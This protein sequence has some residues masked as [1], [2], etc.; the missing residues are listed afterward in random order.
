MCS[1]KAGSLSSGDGTAGLE[2]GTLDVVRFW[3]SNVLRSVLEHL[4]TLD[5]LVLKSASSDNLN[6]V[7]GGGMSSGHLHVHLGDGTAE[8][9][10]S[11]LLVHVNG[12]CT[13]EVTEND[14]V[15]V[16][17]TSLLLEDLTGGDDLALDL[18]DLVLSLHVIPELRPGKNGVSLE[19]SHSVE[20]GVRN[21]LSSEGSSDDKEL[22][23]LSKTKTNIRVSHVIRK[24][25]SSR[26]MH[27]DASN[28]IPGSLY[29]PF[30]S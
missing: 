9:D 29:L 8:R 14:S 25:N 17:G 23:Q 2:W 21:L 22:S 3:E 19:D 16:D 15:V 30:S 1:V 13:G 11:V 4:G 10:V 7:M 6:R 18:A 27:S 28:C 24:L 20:L 26:L 12:T 5:L